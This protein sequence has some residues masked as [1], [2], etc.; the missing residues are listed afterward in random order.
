MRQAVMPHAREASVDDS[1]IER[2]D[3]D[4]ADA[5][6][7]D[8]PITDARSPEQMFRTAVAHEPSVMR[9]IPLVH[10]HV[11]R[12]HLGPAVSPDHMFGWRIVTSKPDIIRLEAEGPLMRGILIGR[13]NSESTAVL[14]TYVFYVRP[15]PA[16]LIWAL[17]GPLHRIA[18]PLLL[19]RAAAAAH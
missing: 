16:R 14:M 10:K 3:Y 19:R 6:E 18:A 11:L 15:M 17:V 1:A 2:R 7:I 13:R 12:F 8:L 5:F 4:Y 9:L